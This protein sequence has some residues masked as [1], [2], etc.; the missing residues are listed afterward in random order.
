MNSCSCCAS[1]DVRRVKNQ[2]PNLSVK[3]ISCYIV[4]VGGTIW[5]SVDKSKSAKTSSSL[6]DWHIV[7]I[8]DELCHIVW[9]DRRRDQV[10]AGREI[11]HCR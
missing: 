1:W 4:G 10:C 11:D 6:E 2:I 5:I 8:S 3:D 9:Q 7:R